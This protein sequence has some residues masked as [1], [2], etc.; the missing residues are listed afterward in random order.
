MR[1]I[2]SLGARGRLLTLFLAG[3]PLMFGT[4][5]ADVSLLFHGAIGGSGETN[6]AGHATVYFSNICADSPIKLRL[7]RPGERGV[8][9]A[10]YPGFGANTD[11]DWIAVPYLSYLYGVESEEEIPLYA[12]GKIRIL[13]RERYRKTHMRDL[14][15]DNADG[16]M[17]EGRWRNTVASLLDREI[18]AFTLKTTPEEDR[19]QLEAFASAPNT[20]Q[21]RTMYR[22]CADFARL[23]INRYFPKATHRDVLNDMTMTTPKAIAKSLTHYAEKRPERLFHITYYPQIDGPIRR[24]LDPRKFTE[25]ALYSKKYFLPMLLKPPLYALFATSYVTTGRFNTYETYKRHATLQIAQLALERQRL[26]RQ[27]RAAPSFPLRFGM[28]WRERKKDDPLRHI[29][30][31]EKHERLRLVG[32]K[33]IWDHY[34]REFAAI[35]KAALADGSFHD[36]EELI[37]FYKDLEYQSRPDFDADGALILHVM[38]R[39]VERTLGITPKNILGPDSDRELAFRLMVTKVRQ[40]LSLAA[41]HRPPLPEFRREW[42]LLTTLKTQHDRMTV[43]QKEANR[44]QPRFLQVTPPPRT[45]QQKRDRLLLILTH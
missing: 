23:T 28:A 38:D 3:L 39:G 16:T 33:E 21:F 18:Y 22:N 45:S 27:K 24:S 17:P 26:Q 44:R 9:I 8:V 12:N 7:C 14:F 43:A 32:D 20:E 13:L 29:A 42:E 6:G 40:A 37:S 31:E 19:I 35:V 4:V 25:K 36:K 2:S 1:Y 30:D 34:K 10:N 15:P 41:K 5:A 11:L